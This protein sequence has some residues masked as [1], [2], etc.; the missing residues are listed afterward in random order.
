ML[1]PISLTINLTMQAYMT[2]IWDD[3]T[4]TS[5]GVIKKLKYIDQH[6]VAFE[7]TDIILSLSKNSAIMI[8]IKIGRK[9]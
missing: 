8:F 2:E 7:D 1:K 3:S 4:S 5:N 6:L 9:I